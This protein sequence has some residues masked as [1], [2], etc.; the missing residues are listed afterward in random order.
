[1]CSIF[2]HILIWILWDARL[3]KFSYSTI[4]EP[5][6]NIFNSSWSRDFKWLLLQNHKLKP[7]DTVNSSS[8]IKP[9]IINLQVLKM[10]LIRTTTVLT[11]LI[12]WQRPSPATLDRDTLAG[13]VTGAYPCYSGQRY[14]LTL[15]GRLLCLEIFLQVGWQEPTPAGGRSRDRS[16]LLLLMAKVDRTGWQ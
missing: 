12:G 15:A 10:Q 4:S 8:W 13:R 7:W 1:M 9:L 2:K 11:G 5:V 3:F 6:Y 16:L 14:F